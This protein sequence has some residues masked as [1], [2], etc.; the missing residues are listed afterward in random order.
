MNFTSLK[1]AEPLRRDPV[2]QL[3]IAPELYNSA[4]YS[5]STDVFS[6]AMCM[7]NIFLLIYVF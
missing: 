7:M 4:E 1:D 5:E 2:H 3:Y 6:F